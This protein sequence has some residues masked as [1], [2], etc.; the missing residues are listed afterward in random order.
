MK[1]TY[2]NKKTGEVRQFTKPNKRL[3]QSKVWV[4]VNK[5]KD[6]IIRSYQAI[7]KRI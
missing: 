3:E 4:R 6:A 7:T 5:I 1:I 2:K